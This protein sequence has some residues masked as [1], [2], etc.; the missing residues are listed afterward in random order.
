MTTPGGALIGQ[1]LGEY[2]L[3]TLLGVG[4]MAEVYQARDA[5]LDVRSPSKCCRWRWRLIR[6]LSSASATRR[7]QLARSTTPTSCR[8]IPLASKAPV[9]TS[10]CR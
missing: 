9:S 10:S 4:G 6:R 8:F 7:K 2:Q 1:W 3:H 5:A